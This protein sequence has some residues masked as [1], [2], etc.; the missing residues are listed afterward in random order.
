MQGRAAAGAPNW[1][2]SRRL[3]RSGR[4]A[5]TERRAEARARRSV[6]RPSPAHITEPD[7]RHTVAA[8]RWEVPAAHEGVAVVVWL[9]GR[10]SKAG[11]VGEPLRGKPV[12]AGPIGRGG[13]TLVFLHLV[14][15]L[16]AGNGEGGH[17]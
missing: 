16:R 9:G 8:R 4:I 11:R 2:V 1:P 14:H 12:A 10:C 6:W 15:R 13:P 3:A 5:P 7:L 17:F